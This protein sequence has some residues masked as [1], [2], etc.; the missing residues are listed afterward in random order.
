MFLAL[1]GGMTAPRRVVPGTYLITR[2]TTRR[3][4]LLRPD[5]D[6]TMAQLYW[7]ATIVYAQLFGLELHVM[8]ML[9]DHVHEVFT[10]PDGL[11][12][13][14]LERR[15]RAIT[16]SVKAHRGWPGEVFD[17]EGPSYQELPTPAALVGKTA[18]VVANCVAAFLVRTPQRW[19]GAKVLVNEIGERVVRV[20]R[21]KYWY[22]AD[23]PQW[24]DAVEMKI[25]MPK[26]L[27]QSFGSMDA[28][29][30]AIQG[31]VDGLVAE[32]HA[33]AK[34]KG[35]GFLGHKRVTRV[36]HTDRASSWEKFGK[37]RPTFVA[38]GDLEV[39]R[40]KAAEKRTFECEHREALLR[41]RAG[42]R[43]V[44]FPRG[45]WMMRRY[46]GVRCRAP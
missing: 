16:L 31:V 1:R 11:L 18:Y 41:W 13:V 34:R 3:H 26:Q 36:P 29:R 2:R 14:F 40:E 22:D 35:R 39:A 10:D 30:A 23:N 17:G 6:G 44:L 15:N 32:A 46:H 20:E 42:E 28:A 5:A 19:P 25:V 45:T 38:A 9:S 8:Q 27:L 7:Y 12:P 24:P 33:E 21:P 37:R 4:F 43:D